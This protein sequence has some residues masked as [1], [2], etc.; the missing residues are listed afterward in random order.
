MKVE[1]E[2][3]Y[4]I[5]DKVLVKQ[6]S[7]TGIGTYNHGQKLPFKAVVSGYAITKDAHKTT[8][9]Y[10]IE[11]LPNE[12]DRWRAYSLSNATTHRRRY[13]AKWLEKVEE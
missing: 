4:N 12:V 9:Y 11:P 6:T 13:N 8:V 7:G 3:K 5:G 2:V 1:I 10:F